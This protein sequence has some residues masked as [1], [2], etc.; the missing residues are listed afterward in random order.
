[1]ATAAIGTKR[2]YASMNGR[3]IDSLRPQ[4][5]L[6]A[7]SSSPSRTSS[8]SQPGGQPSQPTSANGIY[9][10]S[11]G[12]RSR[13]LPRVF[14]PDAS[15][16]IVGARG[17][18]KSSLGV[19]A[20]STLQRRLVETDFIFRHMTGQS[21][22]AYRKAFGSAQYQQKALEVLESILENHSTHCVIVCGLLS[23]SKE[24]QVT[25]ARYA[26][27]HPIVHVVR[28]IESIQAYLGLDQSRVL[29]MVHSAE[30]LFRTCS[31]LEFFNISNDHGDL[32]QDPDA[33]ADSTG[34][35]RHSTPH[36]TLK[37]AER[38]FLKFLALA[39]SI[40]NSPAIGK[41]F[42]LS[43]VAVESRHY[44][45]AMRLSTRQLENS[46]IDAEKLEEGVDAFEVKVDGDVA[47]ITAVSKAIAE[48]RKRTIVPIIYHVP[49]NHLSGEDILQRSRYID[50]VGHGL[51]LASEYV[52]LNLILADE[53][54]TALLA[55]KGKAKMIAHFY[56]DDPATQDWSHPTWIDA[57]RRA[58]R[59]G[60]DIVRLCWPAQRMEDNFQ[61]QAFR[62]RIA[63]LPGPHLPLIAYNT[64][65]LG[66][67][68]ACFN[69][70][71]QPVTHKEF[72]DVSGEPHRPEIS[73]IDATKALFSSFVF[74]PLNFYILG[75]SSSYSLSPAMHN[76]AYTVC[77]M[78]HKYKTFQTSD[79]NEL[80][81]LIND[82]QFGGCSI[83]LPFKLEVM[84]LMHNISSHAKAIGAINTV[85]ALRE[86][87]TGSISPENVEFFKARNRAGPVKSLYGEN[88]DWI[89]IRACVRRGLSPA[90]AVS[91]K[92]TMLV[93]GAG[94]MARA[95]IY[96]V[97][98]LGV[99]NIV[100]YNRTKVNA[101]KLVAHY[102]GLFEDKMKG[103]P[104]PLGISMRNDT[105]L[106]FHCLSSTDEQWPE[107]FSQPTIVVSCIPTH[108]IGDVPSP[109]FV[110]PEHWLQ[111]PTGGVVMEV[112][113]RNIRTP[114][115]EQIRSK[116]AQGWVTMDGL[117]LLPEQA[118]AQFELFTGRRAPRR[119]MRAEV[120]KG[121]R[122]EHG[123]P[124][125][126][127][128]ERRLAQIN[129]QDP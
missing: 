29:D 105:Q 69:P 9:S 113:Y 72:I 25:L 93:I 71:L 116:A 39:T 122:D 84:N 114:L 81:T 20:A 77:G 66:R 22:T 100:V 24:A 110:L 58:Q 79:L 6:H 78:S 51:R 119:L 99:R 23:L 38:C 92:T 61:I 41:V 50:L 70:I 117:D 10:P 74:E 107:G 14:D 120:L 91:P 83:S 60:F 112:A 88:T 2:S 75:A 52:T 7:P 53:D 28:D 97:L 4:K 90:N 98:Q 42:P 34:M 27:T 87:E 40:Q 8:P 49:W 102:Q 45:Y 31:N 109:E 68:S 108:R 21:T 11:A 115:L 126:E 82:P 12:N 33:L 101:E 13:L 43:Q 127:L 65:P 57:Y 118:F 67:T 128:I 30:K 48:L 16:I 94:G 104:S 129:D 62:S 89:G 103:R 106:Q 32:L 46:K 125:P 55:S 80:R 17:T 35:P 124:D 36:L 5:Q 76:A 15:L 63:D 73:A 44:T 1:M 54:L 123:R 56:S 111:S 47:S 121:Y 18:G 59:L 3:A 95:A 85:I 86:S 19:I 26:T 37:K 96:A 64:G